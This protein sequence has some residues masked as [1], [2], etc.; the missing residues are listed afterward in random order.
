MASPRAGACAA[1][2]PAR[3]SAA[4][5]PQGACPHVAGA[6]SRAPPRSASSPA[7][8]PSA[9]A[10]TAWMYRYHQAPPDAIDF[11]DIFTTAPW[12]AK[13]HT[14]TMLAGPGFECVEVT[15]C[16]PPPGSVTRPR[17]LART[18]RRAH[19][20]ENA[21]AAPTRGVPARCS[22]PRAPAR[23]GRLR[24]CT[25]RSTHAPANASTRI[26]R[27]ESRLGA[28][29]HA[30]QLA[31][32][33]CAGARTARRAHRRRFHADPTRGV[34]ARCSLPRAPARR[35]RLRGRA[36]MHAYAADARSA[37]TSDP[38]FFLF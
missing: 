18:D 7:P 31:E 3:P 30:H 36:G 16:G 19:A 15:T 26:P 5:P 28:R 25:N 24:G 12:G 37:E 2:P 23:R 10:S 6:S 38:I 22:L 35:G 21:S 32:D 8:P 9:P 13:P 29:F 1:H 14:L 27:A 17:A 34:P 11:S 4:C 20:P 33:G